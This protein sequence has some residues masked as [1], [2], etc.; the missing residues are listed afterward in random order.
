MAG[1]GN[2]RHMK[3][4]ASTRYMAVGKKTTRYVTK[5]KCG[6]HSLLSSISLLQFVRKV[7][8]VQ[9]RRDARKLVTAEL[10]V[11]N[12]RAV[13]DLKYPVG[14]ND[15]IQIKGSGDAYR[16]G[17]NA[18]GQA[19]VSRVDPGSA[20]ERLCKVV[21]KYIGRKGAVMVGLH[22]GSSVAAQKEVAV[23]DSVVIDSKNRIKKVMKLAEG[24]RC[25]VIAGV[26]VGTSGSIKGIKPGNAKAS[27]SVT[28]SG[29]VGEPFETLLKNI[30][31]VG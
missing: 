30:M 27:P 31:V 28:V 12:G 29:E 16:I 4:L 20:D 22:D 7:G 23:N 1:R 24:S 2:S 13:R 8:I 3:G 14:L 19:D 6:R 10:I 9:S 5:P 26:H 25:M 15:V 17:I 18:R 21:H 11:V